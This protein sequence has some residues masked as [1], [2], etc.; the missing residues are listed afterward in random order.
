M[1]ELQPVG[2]ARNFDKD[3]AVSPPS[4]TCLRSGH[5]FLGRR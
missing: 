3:R 2:L 4:P 1:H 5:T